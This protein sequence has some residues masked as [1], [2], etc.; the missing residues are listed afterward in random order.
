MSKLIKTLI[1]ALFPLFPRIKNGSN[2][3]HN[4]ISLSRSVVF[5]VGALGLILLLF[6]PDMSNGYLLSILLL[7]FL[8]SVLL[9]ALNICSAVYFFILSRFL[10]KKIE[11]SPLTSKEYLTFSIFIICALILFLLV[12]KNSYIF[13]DSQYTYNS[14]YSS[15]GY[16]QI[17]GDW[18]DDSKLAKEVRRNQI[19]CDESVMECK[20]ISASIQEWNNNYFSVD[21]SVFIIDSWEESSVNA[22]RET[23]TIREEI[24]LYP[25]SCKMVYVKTPKA[26]A[27]ENSLFGVMP[28]DVT[29]TMTSSSCR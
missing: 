12:L 1:D 23:L 27:A 19:T 20:W 24:T 8:I 22:S 11:I 2:N 3:F 13:V 29:L 18:D 6:N 7:I 14:F 9:V 26:D 16:I 10:N 5:I 25:S 28:D 17:S 4:F 15:P 21:D